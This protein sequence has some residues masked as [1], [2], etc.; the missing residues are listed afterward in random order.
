M[1]STQNGI[2]GRCLADLPTV[3]Q[4]EVHQEIVQPQKLPASPM[5]ERLMAVDVMNCCVLHLA[6]LNMFPRVAIYVHSKRCGEVQLSHPGN[7][8]FSNSDGSVG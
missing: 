8:Q 2:A 3:Q 4:P 5:T 1:Q 6:K 7:K